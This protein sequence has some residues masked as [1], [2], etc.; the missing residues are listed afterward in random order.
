M[1]I[2]SEYTLTLP[3]KVC[4]L[5]THALRRG[6][7]YQELGCCL[8]NGASRA[9]ALT[10]ATV[11]AISQPSRCFHVSPRENKND[12]V[13][14]STLRALNGRLAKLALRCQATP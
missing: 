9:S 5:G 6:R 10:E 3:I 12:G 8:S 1:S 13:L 4:I 11:L 7:L 14:K 2:F